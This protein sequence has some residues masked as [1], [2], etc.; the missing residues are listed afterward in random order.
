MS[1]EQ[2]MEYEKSKYLG[3]S[4][5]STHL[6]KGLDFLLLRKI[7]ADQGG[8][9]A[10]NL[11]S[12][13]ERLVDHHHR[14]GQ[15]GSLGDDDD[16]E[17]VECTSGLGKRVLLAAI[18]R[19]GA[20]SKNRRGP[21]VA[22]ELFLPARMYYQFRLDAPEN[23]GVSSAL[24]MTM[25]I[26]SQGE[27][28]RLVADGAVAAM[29]GL[30]DVDDRAS[31]RVVIAKVVSAIRAAREKRDNKE[32][33]SVSAGKAASSEAAAVVAEAPKS[34][35]GSADAASFDSDDD[36]F[37]DAGVDY[38][39]TVEKAQEADVEEHLVGPAPLPPDS[40]SD[41]DSDDGDGSDKHD[42]DVDSDEEFAVVAP[43]PA[44]MSVDSSDD[45]QVTAPYP[46]SPKSRE[47]K[48]PRIDDNDN[49]SDR[50]DDNLD[51]RLFAEARLRF[52][53]ETRDLL[54]ETQRSAAKNPAK[55]EK[56]S[57]GS[58]NKEWQQTRKIMK[59]KYGV[60]IADDSVKKTRTKKDMQKANKK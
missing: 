28:A 19:R 56:A 8:G 44:A 20:E 39:V 30:Y 27:V 11:D 57:S 25:R 43:Y 1:E 10:E 52:K 21:V 42:K 23:R 6:V 48:R 13:L 15:P 34:P 50:D 18:K 29:R 59:E 32:A 49:N 60:D 31:D 47:A 16:E 12:E 54:Y 40:N 3:G 46:E 26:R 7:R 22:N 36:I 41:S 24:A 51:M 37:A 4:V 45:E 38:E 35:T 58:L 33:A 17:A 9:G 55:K 14:Q 53:E 2:R 5:E